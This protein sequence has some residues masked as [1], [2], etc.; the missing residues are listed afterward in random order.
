[1]FPSTSYSYAI[2]PK[3]LKLLNWAGV[4]N[5]CLKVVKSGATKDAFRFI[6]ANTAVLNG[7]TVVCLISLSVCKIFTNRL[8][9]DRHS[10]VML[11]GAAND[12]NDCYKPRVTASAWINVLQRDLYG[13]FLGIQCFSGYVDASMDGPKLTELYSRAFARAVTE[14][15]IKVGLLVPYQTIRSRDGTNKKHNYFA[16][17][18]SNLLSYRI[19]KRWRFLWLFYR[20]LGNWKRIARLKAETCYLS[21]QILLIKVS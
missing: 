10:L 17:H 13:H 16:W 1:M 2:I 19:Q 7:V 9:E 21:F 14:E 11:A 12:N 15:L 8:K 4:N 18:G 3:D 20:S 6:T 5:T